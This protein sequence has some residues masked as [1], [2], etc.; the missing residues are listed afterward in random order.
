MEPLAVF[1]GIALIVA[2][3]WD[4][5]KS[6]LHP[7]GGGV[8]GIWLV[9]IISRATRIGARSYPALIEL[10]GPTALALT[11]AIW[12][13]AL[14]FGWALVYWPSMPQDFAFGS[15]LKPEHHAGFADALYVSLV[16]LATLGYGDIAPA[17]GWFRIIAPLE[18]LVGLGLFTATLTWIL[19]LYPILSRR[20]NLARQVTL[21]AEAAQELEMSLDALRARSLEH[22]LEELAKATI[23]IHEDLVQVP[24]VRFFRTSDPRCSA[25]VALCRA[26]ELARSLDIESTPSEL[27]LR[28]RALR[29]AVDD[30]ADVL[31]C[32]LA[33]GK[34]A[35]TTEVLAEFDGPHAR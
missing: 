1:A 34:E 17:G 11:V 33:R 28:A 35:S 2:A 8:I 4:I 13:G 3:L 21:I 7:T 12:A 27:R 31:R 23:A 14:A 30:T 32:D 29:R 25:G 5:T 16:T 26:H 9:R 22:L 18:A 15:G 19:S 10:G 6:L 24:I 20:R